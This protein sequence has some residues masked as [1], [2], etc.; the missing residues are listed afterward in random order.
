[1]LLKANSMVAAARNETTRPGAI[2]LPHAPLA[3]L[4]QKSP[5]AR[6]LWVPRRTTAPRRGLLR[7][8]WAV[9]PFGKAVRGQHRE[10][11]VSCGIART[12]STWRLLSD[13]LRRCS[14]P[15]RTR[16]RPGAWVN[17]P[18]PRTNYLTYFLPF[19]AAFFAGFFAAFLAAFFFVA[20][21]ILLLSTVEPTFSHPG[22]Q[23]HDDRPWPPGP[24]FPRGHARE[25]HRTGTIARFCG[26][27]R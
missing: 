20:M 3:I 26:H 4:R 1:M 5:P 11:P 21:R 27:S 6:R 17:G 22:V 9:K 16:V 18:S 14:E 12:P 8:Y 25:V 23:T 15:R 19:F 10:R 13:T 2:T 7:N 24:F